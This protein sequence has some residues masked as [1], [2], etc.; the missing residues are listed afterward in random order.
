MQAL[1]SREVSKR[2]R[3]ALSPPGYQDIETCPQR[4]PLGGQLISVPVRPAALQLPSARTATAQVPE[5]QANHW[6]PSAKEL[7][8]PSHSSLPLHYHC[9]T[10]CR[11]P[12]PPPPPPWPASPSAGTLKICSYELPQTA[13]QSLL[14]DQEFVGGRLGMV[15]VRPPGPA[16]LP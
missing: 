12:P 6:L 8:C 2:H 10:S 4:G 15:G 5:R 16:K 14:Q 7:C 1:P 13:L 9:P 11:A 3:C